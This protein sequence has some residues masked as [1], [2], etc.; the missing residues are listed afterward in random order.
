MQDDHASS[1]D[2]HVN[3]ACDTFGSLGAQ[4]SKLAF[5]ML[6]VRFPQLLQANILDRLHE[7][8]EPGLKAGRQ[9]L[10]F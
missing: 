5:Q 3:A 10:D 2:G 9:R 8:D 7:A 1:G 6:D 4:L